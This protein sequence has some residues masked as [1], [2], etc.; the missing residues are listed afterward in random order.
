MVRAGLKQ[1]LG[2]ET[3]RHHDI[4]DN[5]RVSESYWR[6]LSKGKGFPVVIMTRYLVK[7]LVYN[8][9]RAVHQCNCVSGIRGHG[10]WVS[11]KGLEFMVPGAP[12][13]G[14]AVDCY[15]ITCPLFR[16]VMDVHY[17]TETIR[18]RSK[19]R[20]YITTVNLGWRPHGNTVP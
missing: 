1:R 8:R 19:M 20:T 12:V 6:A 3:L 10:P 5:A 15:M 14:K 18:I 17:Q 2:S 16:T 9:F 4:V 7:T 13:W 11:A